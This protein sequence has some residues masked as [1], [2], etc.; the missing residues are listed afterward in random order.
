MHLLRAPVKVLLCGH[1]FCLPCIRG[2][3]IWN[4]H[5]KIN[6]PCPTCR[7]ETLLPNGR[8][9]DLSTNYALNEFLDKERRKEG[10][11]IE[12]EEQTVDEGANSSLVRSNGSRQEND[13]EQDF[14][15]TTLSTIK[16]EL[17]NMGKIIANITTAL[18]IES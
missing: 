1:S 15:T 11:N 3:Q 12:H 2:M 4:V 18:E 17:L 8:V 5:G 13:E 9:N 6:L 14:L 7:R 16:N 10:K